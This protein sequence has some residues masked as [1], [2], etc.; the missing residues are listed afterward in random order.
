ME[1]VLANAHALTLYVQIAKESWLHKGARLS[2]RIL[3]SSPYLDRSYLPAL[4][5][6]SPAA[7]AYSIIRT[8]L[9]RVR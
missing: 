1:K 8:T 7:R 6:F 3:A 2:T 5:P 4:A 9:F